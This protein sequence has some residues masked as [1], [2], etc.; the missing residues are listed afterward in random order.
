[1]RRI[2]VTGG[3][4]FIGSALIRYIIQTQEDAECLFFRVILCFFKKECNVLILTW[5]PSLSPI[6]STYCHKHL[7]SIYQLKDTKSLHHSQGSE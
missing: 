5:I 3:A 7:Q 2:L 4:G 1:V 6:I